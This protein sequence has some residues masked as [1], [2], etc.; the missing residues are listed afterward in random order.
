MVVVHTG[1]TDA[2]DRHGGTAGLAVDAAHDDAGGTTLHLQRHAAR[3]T[4]AA[5]AARAADGDRA[6]AAE[7]R[8]TGLFD[9]GTQEHPIGNSGRGLSTG[10]LQGNGTTVGDQLRA[11]A[12]VHALIPVGQ[13]FAART[14]GAAEA[15]DQDRAIAEGL[16]RGGDGHLHA[17]GVGGT[18][19]FE[20][21]RSAGAM[22]GDLTIHRG[23]RTAAD[24]LDAPRQGSCGR[25]RRAGDRERAGLG[26]EAGVVD[27]HASAVTTA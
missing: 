4:T 6:T 22:Q 27:E 16:Q 5:T 23:Q 15:L 7:D 13:S 18:T 25:A 21:A 20:A 8:R 9:Q 12:E 14:L 19:A 11:A 17:K 3:Q 24:D 2:G 26:A 1:S 10:A